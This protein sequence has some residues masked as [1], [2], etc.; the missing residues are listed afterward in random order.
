MRAAM[1]AAVAIMALAGLHAPA[2]AQEPCPCVLPDNGTG[3]VTMPPDCIDGYLGH[4]EIAE[5]LGAATIEIEAALYGAYDVVEVPGGNL[6]GTRSTFGASLLMEMTGTGWLGGFSRTI[7]LPLSGVMD[8][9]PRTPNDA[10]QAF[11]GEITDL[12]GEVLGGP[13]FDQLR[14]LA[15]TDYAL[16]GPG[17]T[18]LT[19][20]GGIGS[21]FQVE[22]F[23]DM[24]YQIEW[25]GALGSV[26]EGHAGTDTAITRIA[27]CPAP[28]PVEETTWGTLKALYQ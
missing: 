17:E 27:V 26:L 24:T 6:G 8:W 4:L 28:V 11:P 7:N 3:T 21:D 20:Q 10:V 12:L 18:I 14:F 16:P 2:H 19:R 9:G 13:D 5:G 15:G 23:F 1:L 22:S 25:V